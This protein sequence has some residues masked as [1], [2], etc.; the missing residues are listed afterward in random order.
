MT[1]G[2]F[3]KKTEIMMEGITV[4]ADM[5]GNY[6]KS[7]ELITEKDGKLRKSNWK[8]LRRNV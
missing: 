5:E 8:R 6:G 2:R 3:L 7:N 4:G 1:G